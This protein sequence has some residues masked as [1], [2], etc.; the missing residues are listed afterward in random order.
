MSAAERRGNAIFDQDSNPFPL[1]VPRIPQNAKKNMTKVHGKARTTQ[2]CMSS[3]G[4]ISAL[5]KQLH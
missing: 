3:E 4:L 5:R 2:N 1:G